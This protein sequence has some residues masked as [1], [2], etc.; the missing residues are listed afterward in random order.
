M[1]L[2][3]HNASTVHEMTNAERDTQMIHLQCDVCS[4]TATCVLTPS[5]TLAWCEHMARHA[6]Q[7]AYRAWH[8]VVVPLFD[9]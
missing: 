5:A 8:W 9:L 3:V 4:M 2:H 1:H 6:D 7:S